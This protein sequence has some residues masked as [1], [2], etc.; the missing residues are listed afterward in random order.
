MRMGL[1]EITQKE[2]E[3]LSRPY[4][5]VKHVSQ[6]EGWGHPLTSKILTQKCSCLKEIQ[7]QRVEQRVK[8]RPCRDCPIWGSIPHTN[9]KPRHYC[10]CQEV[11]ADRSLITAVF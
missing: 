5:D 9:T 3:N 11:L 10:Q 6:V 7:G 4:A 2:E 8:E 1:A